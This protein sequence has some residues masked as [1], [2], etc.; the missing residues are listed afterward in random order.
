MQIENFHII[1]IAVRTTNQNGQSGKDIGELWGRF[2]AENI[3]ERIPNKLSSTIYGVYTDYEGDY[4]KPYTAI[5]GCKVANLDRVPEGMVG[6]T[7]PRGKFVQFTA[8]GNLKEGVVFSEWLKIWGM[9]LDRKYSADFEVYGE[10]AQNPEHAEVDIFIA[11][12]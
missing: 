8:K 7:I 2:F 11:L 6:K 1:G 9:P 5:V 10:K 3:L 12:L 4:M